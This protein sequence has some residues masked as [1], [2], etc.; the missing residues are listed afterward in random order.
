[1]SCGL[2]GGK[3]Y[4]WGTNFSGL[5]GNG[6]WSG[7]NP[8]PLYEPAEVVGGLTFEA[9]ALGTHHACALTTAGVAYCWGLGA[10]GALGTGVHPDSA[11]APTAVIGGLTFVSLAA[12][13]FGEFTC[14]VITGGAAYCWGAGYSGELGTGG[15]ADTAGP[16]PVA[17]GFTFVQV[18]TGNDHACGLTTS[19]AAYCW[20]ESD[21]VGDS[22]VAACGESC[23][24]TPQPVDGGLTFATLTAGFA[25][26]CGLTPAGA[27]YCWGFAT[28]NG[29]GGSV[30]GDGS[31]FNRLS[32]T[33]VA[34]GLT[35]VAISAGL[36]Q[37]C[38]M[39]TNG[40]AYCWGSAIAGDLGNG[41]MADAVQPVKV[42]HP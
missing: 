41:T 27:A 7:N 24:R 6:T 28:T 36:H 35:F 4:C 34:G 17:G 37:T 9:I 15:T 32:P 14:G 18:T 10:T 20:G 31:T 3:A 16:V 30:L 38:A 21:L 2:T 11:N 12:S 39:T 33:P 29:L 22:A 8:G 13:E 26:T 19:G 40:E 1:V 5:L 25:H 23:S 42:T